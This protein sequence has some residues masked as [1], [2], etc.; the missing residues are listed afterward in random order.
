MINSEITEAGKQPPT[1]TDQRIVS[2]V[3]TTNK[4]GRPTL[5]TPETL[6]RLL[7]ALADGLTQKQACLATELAKAP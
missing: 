3:I 4:G 1:E 2:A 6:E 5:Y 7:T